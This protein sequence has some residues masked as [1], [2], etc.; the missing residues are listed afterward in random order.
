MKLPKGLPSVL[1]VQERRHGSD[2]ADAE[3]ALRAEPLGG[4]DPPTSTLGGALVAEFIS[5]QK[6]RTLSV[7]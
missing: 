6:K 4:K 2:A 3:H 5:P 7:L 1:H